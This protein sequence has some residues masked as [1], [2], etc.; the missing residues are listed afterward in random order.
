MLCGLLGTAALV[1]Y[2]S[3][4]FTWMPLPPPNATPDQVLAFGS[5]YHNAILWDTWLQAIGSLL[6]VVFALALVDLAGAAQRLA[7]RLVL[8]AGGVILVLSLM[9]GTFALGAVQAGANGH[10]QAAL[11]CFDLTNTFIHVFLI[12]PSLFLMLGAALWGT[13]LL[14]AAFAYVALGLGIAFQVL[15]VVGLFNSAALLVVIFVLIAQ[16]LWN[17]AAAIV[18]LARPLQPAVQAEAA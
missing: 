9:E 11:T 6:S 5:Q 15:G 10:P 18:L 1:A 14:P 4:P 16:E 2:Y 17:V 7:G 8:L 3:A 13:R 12:A